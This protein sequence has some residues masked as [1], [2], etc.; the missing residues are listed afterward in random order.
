MKFIL[1]FIAALVAA[2]LAVF[3]YPVRVPLSKLT[4]RVRRQFLLANAHLKFALQV[5][6]NDFLWRVSEARLTLANEAGEF[7]TTATITNLQDKVIGPARMTLKDDVLAIKDSFD[8]ERGSD[9][10]DDTFNSPK[11]PGV[12]AFGLS[13]G[14]DMVS[15]TMTDSNVPVSATE[16]GVS[17]EVTNKNLR[18]VGSTDFLR[19]AGIQ[20]ASA[21]NVKQE[22][23]FATLIDGFG[24][25][26]GADGSAATIGNLSAALAQLRTNSEPVNE[27]MMRDVSA[28]VHPYGWHD[29]SAELFPAGSTNVRPGDDPA[30]RTF[31]SYF[32]VGEY[33]G[34]P[35][36]LST[37][38]VESSTD[39]RSGVFHRGAGLIYEFMPVTLGVDDSDK[40]MRSVELN[41]VID[42]GYVEIL[43]GHGREWDHDI[44]APTS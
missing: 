32:P 40:S 8:I 41:M 27:A 30:N 33:F 2:C 12:T 1:F 21:I 23:D 39:I 25:A 11:L 9:G 34:T 19:K 13:E 15:E 14:V 22:Q 37:N 31:N 36:K 17:V 5:L 20:M 7:T 3:H 16:V 26:V 29:I 38:L 42:Y 44:T 35:I 6:R 28:V 24:N 10:M 4:R 18:T 43:D